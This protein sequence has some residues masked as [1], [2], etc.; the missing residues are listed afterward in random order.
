MFNADPVNL[1]RPI[2]RVMREAAN[3][4]R[5]HGAHLADRQDDLVKRLEAPYTPRIQRAVRSLLSDKILTGPEKASQLLA[6][7]DQLGLVRQ[8]APE[9]LPAIEPDDIHL[10][11]WAIV[12]CPAQASLENA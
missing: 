11:C 2:P 6:L 8:P 4:V 5:T 3:L 7:A 10:I 12:L 1:T 9:P